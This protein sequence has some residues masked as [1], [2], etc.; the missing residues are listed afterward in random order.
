MSEKIENHRK[1]AFRCIMETVILWGRNALSDCSSSAQSPSAVFLEH[2]V[3]LQCPSQGNR[4]KQDMKCGLC[5][6]KV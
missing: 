4:T 6:K 2:Y 5:L 1:I 3:H